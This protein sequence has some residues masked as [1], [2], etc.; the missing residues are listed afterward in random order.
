MS[1][2]E[3]DNATHN[4]RDEMSRDSRA[5]VESILTLAGLKPIRMWELVN[6]YWP[7]SPNYD[8]VRKPW[9]LA[10]T[11]V[12]LIRIGWRKRVMT[13]DWE[14]T[15]VRFIVTDDDVT[16][17]DTMVHAWSAAK[18][19]EY[20]SNLRAFVASGVGEGSETSVP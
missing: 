6:G 16:K 18:A 8:D 3:R 14:A 13:I 19:V 1:D 10:Q 4:R 7:N 12:G 17:G 9:W 5:E 11:S 15:A 2:W 20:M